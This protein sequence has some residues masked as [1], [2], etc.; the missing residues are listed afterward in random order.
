MSGKTTSNLNEEIVDGIQR[1]PSNGIKVIVIGA[2]V[3]G[4][5]TALECW[6]AGC[7]PI[8]LERADAISPIGESSNSCQEY[9]TLTSILGDFFTI[10]PSGL[11]TLKCYPAMCASYHERTFDC[12]VSVWRPDGT[13]VR[14]QYPEWRRPG[15]PEKSAAPD[16]SVSFIKQRPVFTNMLYDQCMRLGIPVL[17][18]QK[19]DSATE[20]ETGVEIRTED[21]TRYTGDVCVA[22]AGIGSSFTRSLAMPEPPVQDSG[23]AIARMAFPRSAI[24]PDSPAAELLK[25]VDTQPE[26][27]VY[28]GEDLHLILYLTTDNVG[29]AYTHEVRLRHWI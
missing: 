17:F 20:S 21:G 29:F 6:R 11:S 25:T 10:P 1:S 12:T 7:D 8:V 22:A 5:L 14:S 13:L 3:G 23:Y 4:L 24:K 2:G 28:L 9:E 16:V 27:R 15:A 26:F 19:A 18:G